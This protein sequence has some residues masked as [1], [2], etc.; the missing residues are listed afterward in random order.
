MPLAALLPPS[1]PAAKAVVEEEAKDAGGNPLTELD[2]NGGR[3]PTFV[4]DD[5]VVAVV[6]A[7]PAFTPDGA[8]KVGLE[9]AGAAGGTPMCTDATEDNNEEEE[10]EEEEAAADTDEAVAAARPLPFCCCCC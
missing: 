3:D 7:D 10:E 1:P 5:V 8:A 9:P 6:E 4:A 2:A